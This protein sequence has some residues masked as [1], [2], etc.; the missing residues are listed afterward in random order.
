MAKSHIIGYRE[1]QVTCKNSDKKH[2]NLDFTLFCAIRPL[3]YPKL[4]SKCSRKSC[5]NGTWK[6]KNRIT[7]WRMKRQENIRPSRSIWENIAGLSTMTGILILAILSDKRKTQKVG[8]A[9][10]IRASECSYTRAVKNEESQGK[11]P[12]RAK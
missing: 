5:N 10:H 9:R 7:Q 8:K 12:R 2:S 4:F 3:C 6:M 11:A 1:G